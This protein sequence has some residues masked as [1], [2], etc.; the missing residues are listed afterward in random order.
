MSKKLDKLINT[1]KT[2]PLP[3][4]ELVYFLS[5]GSFFL[6]PNA[7]LEYLIANG[8]PIEVINDTLYLKTLITPISEQIFCVVDIE[9]NGSKPH[10]SQII[11]IGAL[12]VKNSQIID[13]FESFVNCVFVPDYISKITGI[14]LDDTI[15]APDLQKVMQ[16][17]RLFLGDAV[18]VA[19]NVNFDYNFISQSLKNCGLG[20]LL[21]RK[22]CTINLAKKTIQSEKYALSY[23]NEHLNIK[24]AP[25]HR[26]YNDALIATKVFIESLKRLPPEVKSTEDLI[27]FSL[28]GL[29]K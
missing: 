3:L 1:L 2:K 9:T 28:K 8:I 6:D 10:N 4:S 15:Y 14:S 13:R 11:E 20:E 16:D 18:F 5:P 27:E 26:A 24:H 25:L 17:F 21:N 19:H 7:E 22:L 23:L 29:N 12:K